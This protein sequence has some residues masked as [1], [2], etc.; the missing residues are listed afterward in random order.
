MPWP[1]TVVLVL[2][3]LFVLDR[4]LLAAE[5][6]GWIYYRVKKPSTTGAGNALV[7]LQAMLN[8]ASQHVIVAQKEQKAERTDDGG[9]PDDDWRRFDGPPP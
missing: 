2:V 5:R 7:E 3:G 4:L 1:L 8:P 9:P 6:R